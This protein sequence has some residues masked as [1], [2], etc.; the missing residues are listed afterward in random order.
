[1]TANFQ[2]KNEKVSIEQKIKFITNK[3]LSLFY[4]FGRFVKSILKFALM[5]NPLLF[6][7]TL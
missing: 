7:K 3:L 5:I 4:S 2:W 1:M 6:W